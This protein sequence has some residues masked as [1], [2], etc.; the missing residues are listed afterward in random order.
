MFHQSSRMEEYIFIVI[1]ILDDILA[2][3]TVIIIAI[4]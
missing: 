2:P 1:I 4:I 3:F